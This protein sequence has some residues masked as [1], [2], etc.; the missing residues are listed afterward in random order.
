MRTDLTLSADMKHRTFRSFCLTLLGCLCLHSAWAVDVGDSLLELDLPDTAVARKVSDLRG[1][2][3]YLDFW[4]SW[5]GPCRQSFPWMSALQSRYSKEQL[6]VIG[7]NVDAKRADADRFLAR[8][9][10]GFALA[11]DARGESAKKLAIKTMPTSVLINPEGR[12]VWVHQGFR[13]EDEA[14]LTTQVA[15]ALSAAG[16]K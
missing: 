3:V 15:A 7:M 11:F 14:Q 4:A 16:K 10:A 12:V 1:R 2:F 9:P 8:N 5:C 6:L 13:T